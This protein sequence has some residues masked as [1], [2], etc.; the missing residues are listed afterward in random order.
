MAGRRREGLKFVRPT[1]CCAALKRAWRATKYSCCFAFVLLRAVS[2]N[3]PPPPRLLPVTL[4]C[5]AMRRHWARML[6]T[7]WC[8]AQLLFSSA[9]AGN[10][11]ARLILLSKVADALSTGARYGLAGRNVSGFPGVPL[12]RISKYSIA[13]PFG[14]API[15]AIRCPATTASPSWTATDCV[16]P[17][18][19]R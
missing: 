8:I 12:M 9:S 14:P 6:D 15:V 13:S 10:L 4:R 2:S 18:A 11:R 16:C 17:Y 5:V 3:P 1:R 19:L 7:R